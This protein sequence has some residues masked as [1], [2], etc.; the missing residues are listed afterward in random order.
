MYAT[1]FLILLPSAGGAVDTVL[2]MLAGNT[3]PEVMGC[4][5]SPLLPPLSRRET[6][7]ESKVLEIRDSCDTTGA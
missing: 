2:P 4:I 6:Y 5:E 7:I 1:L 3:T